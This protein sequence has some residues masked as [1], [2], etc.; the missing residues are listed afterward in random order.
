MTFAPRCLPTMVG[1]LPLRDP[2]E[3]CE[4]VLRYLRAIP[5]WPQL[6]RRSFRENMYAQYGERFPGLVVDLER[7]KVWVDRERA[8]E[9]LEALYLAYLE[10]RVDEW[11]IGPEYAAGLEAFLRH[12]EHLEG[13]VAVKGQVT[14]PISMGLQVTDA[15]LRP[16]LY[17]EILAD[18]VAKH[19]RL[20]AAWMERRL[21]RLHPQVILFVDEPYLSTF[22]SA[23]V[24]LSREQVITLIGEV[25]AGISGL[26]GIHCCGNTDWSVVLETR[27][28]ILNL[29]AYNYAESLSL[30]PEAVHA[31][32]HRGGIIAWGIVPQEEAAIRTATVDDLFQRL[33]A[34]W[35]LLEA[36]GISRDDLLSSCL[37]TPSC[38]LGAVS[39]EAAAR[40]L[41]L[42]VAVSDR[43]RERYG[44]Q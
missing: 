3:A 34:A 28:D 17:D 44:V 23:F 20:K 32:L 24:S 13:A 27:P 26:K 1:S 18:A 6:P 11:G 35:G 16:I 40:A 39:P 5:A 36:K 22:G 4:L 42:T 14:G 12:R 41:E 21:R 38:G 19:L 30:Y 25:F 31:F 2:R 8:N 15:A 37:I 29:D 10:D 7:E 43:V 33:E 9:E